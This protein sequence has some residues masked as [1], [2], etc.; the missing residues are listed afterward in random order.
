MRRQAF[1]K[2]GVAVLV[3]QCVL[4]G[5]SAPPA[6]AASVSKSRNVPSNSGET[7]DFGRVGEEDVGNLTVK[8]DAD[9]QKFNGKVVNADQSTWTGGSGWTTKPIHFTTGQIKNEEAKDT[10]GDHRDHFHGQYQKPGGQGMK[11][12]GGA[13]IWED[14]K[15]VV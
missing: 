8:K 14:R 2:N 15:S 10:P 9:V 11:G 3:A 5:L 4:F 7:V 13:A 1:F 6:Q 12:N